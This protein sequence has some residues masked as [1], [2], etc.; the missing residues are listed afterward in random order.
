MIPH[1]KAEIPEGMKRKKMWQI[2]EQYGKFG[3]KKHR[4]KTHDNRG[5]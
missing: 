4:T 5:I 1:G 2:N 3:F